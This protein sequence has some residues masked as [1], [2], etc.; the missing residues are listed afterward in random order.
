MCVS[1]TLDLIQRN[2]T[3]DTRLIICC[4]SFSFSTH[5]YSSIGF[6]SPFCTHICELI[7]RADWMLKKRKKNMSGN[8]FARPKRKPKRRKCV[9]RYIHNFRLYPWW[10]HH[11]HQNCKKKTILRFD[12]ECQGKFQ[13][14]FVNMCVCFLF[15]LFLL[16]FFFGKIFALYVKKQMGK[17]CVGKRPK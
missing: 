6:G 2:I 10:F 5:I 7:Q 14:Q 4:F 11:C 17:I 3:I 9:S 12:P 13:I 15:K 1:T 16:F 8:F